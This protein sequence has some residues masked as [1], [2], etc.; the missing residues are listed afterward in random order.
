MQISI[1]TVHLFRTVLIRDKHPASKMR[2]GLAC[3]PGRT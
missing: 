3:G 2:A 1:S